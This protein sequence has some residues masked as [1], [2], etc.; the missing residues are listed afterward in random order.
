MF[1]G[2]ADN[3][4]EYRLYD[5]DNLKVKT[6]RSVKLDEREVVGIYDTR[7]PQL[8]T[9]VRVTTEHDDENLSP[10][11]IEQLTDEPMEV[12]E[13][14][15]MDVEMDK[16]DKM[17]HE[18]MV[19]YPRLWSSGPTPVGHELTEYSPPQ[20]IFEEDRLVFHP[21]TTFARRSREPALLLEDE[22]NDDEAQKPEWRDGPPS[23]K[24]ARIDDEELLAEAA[25]L[26]AANFDGIPDTPNTCARSIPS[27]EADV[28]SKAIDA[29]L[30]SH[31]QNHTWTLFRRKNYNPFDW[32]PLGFR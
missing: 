17:E 23:P 8:E 5:L 1:L 15:G 9:I 10:V 12:D 6:S 30:H 7:S 19:N 25:L 24:R 2:Y 22:K 20:P 31:A 32:V 11:E 16:V 3:V 27:G 29:E 26:Y 28:W 14:P 18:Q 21:E 13:D 4:K